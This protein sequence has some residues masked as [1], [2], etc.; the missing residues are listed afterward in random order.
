MNEIYCITKAVGGKVMERKAEEQRKKSA[1]N[2]KR[3]QQKEKDSLLFRTA[4]R[5]LVR[6][7]RLLAGDI[8]C[9]LKR[10]KQPD[11]SPIKTKMVDLL[12]Q[13]HRR[14]LRF[15]DYLINYV[16]T[17]PPVI[18]NNVPQIFV[19]DAAVPAIFVQDTVENI[20]QVPDPGVTGVYIRILQRTK[21]RKLHLPETSETRS[22]K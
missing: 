15:D 17:P 7:E 4:Y 18:E 20:L 10:C 3:R 21:I 5:K 22:R 19:E 1:T 12:A 11:D 13:W 2:Q 14:K 9:L 16:P 8:C 6:N